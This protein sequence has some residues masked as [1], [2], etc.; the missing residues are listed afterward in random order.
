MTKTIALLLLLL[1]SAALAQQRQLL[2]RRRPQRGPSK[3]ST[4]K[5][6]PRSTIRAGASRGGPRPAAAPPFNYDSA[7]RRTGSS[8]TPRR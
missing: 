5:A 3:S 4:A 8:V 7:G 6:R 1:P 2:R